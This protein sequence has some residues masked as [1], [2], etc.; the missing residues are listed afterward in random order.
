MRRISLLL[1]ATALVFGLACSESEKDAC[2]D[3]QV[4]EDG[5]CRAKPAASAGSS[6]QAGSTTTSEG[7]V[8]AGEGGAPAAT[9]GGAPGATDGGA[10]TG[11]SPF[12]AT[13]A[14]HADCQAPTDYCAKS[15]V[16]PPYCT[17]SGCDTAPELCPDGWTCFDVSQF[18]PGE[19]WICMQPL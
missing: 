2:G 15:P 6:A 19:P 8:P 17:A 5:A 9:D 18:A 14:D 3:Q 4:Y 10:A 11:D 7:G 12:G 13:C 16:A 1:T